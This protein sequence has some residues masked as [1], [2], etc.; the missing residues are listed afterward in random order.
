MAPRNLLVALVAV[1]TAALVVG[2]AIERNSGEAGHQDSA[3]RV[4]PASGETG[5]SGE[6]H[7]GAGD[8]SAA[9]HATESTGA[10]SKAAGEKPHAELRPLGVDIEAWPFVAIAAVASLAFALSAWLRPRLTPL[11]A[12][13]AVAMLAF[14]A[15]DVREVVHQLDIDKSGLAV[16]ASGIAALHALAA[17]VAAA[18]TSRARRPHSGRPGTMP[19]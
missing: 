7:T 12:L 5:A 9:A 3:T 1:A 14:A 2:T 15:L 6:T 13:V 18:M 17:A 19:A 16:L 11:L 10:A 4:A 8:E